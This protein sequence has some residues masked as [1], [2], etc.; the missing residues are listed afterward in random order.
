MTSSRPNRYS[1]ISKGQ[2]QKLSS[3]NSVR[4]PYTSLKN[5]SFNNDHKSIYFTYI[6]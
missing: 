5:N 6:E 4:R 1:Y 2:G 3:G